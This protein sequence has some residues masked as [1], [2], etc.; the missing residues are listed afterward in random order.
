MMST[1]EMEDI[2]MSLMTAFGSVDAARMWLNMSQTLRGRRGDGYASSDAD[3]VAM[4]ITSG[5][6]RFE[7]SLLELAD[8]IDWSAPNGGGDGV[9]SSG[10]VIVGNTS[11]TPQPSLAS[12]SRRLSDPDMEDIKFYLAGVVNPALCVFGLVGNIFNI[13]VLSRGRMKATLD[14]SMELAAHT[15]L[16]ALAVSDMLYCASAFFDALNSRPQTAFLNSTVWLYIQIYGPYFQNTFLHTGTWLTVIMA[17]GRYAAICR[18]LQARHLVGVKATLGAIATTFLVWIALEL[19]RLWTYAIIPVD[20]PPS[21]D[22]FYVLD[23]GPFVTNVRLKMAFTYVWAVV[24]FFLPVVTLFYC[25]VH[26]IRALRESIRV[27]RLY[28]VS[29]KTTSPGSRIS[30]TLVAIVCMYIVLISPSEVLHFYYYTVDGDDVEVFNMAIVVTNVLQTLNFAFNFVLYC[31]VNVH[32]RQT[33]MEI[34]LCAR[35]LHRWQAASAC[36]GHCGAG[37]GGGG[38][39]TADGGG[40]R[41]GE[42]LR[43][44]WHNSSISCT[45]VYTRGT[46]VGKSVYETAL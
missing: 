13:L 42:R 16:I 21:A 5:D 38:G 40:M 11:A 36:C 23:E 34:L 43:R 10:Y 24:G 19:P 32:F 29:A 3:D 37:G 14:C 1:S 46:Y 2:C 8:G 17:A 45:V 22:R 41:R 26:L 20:C 18:P 12:S 31:I 33:S 27:R 39:G 6:D 4:T 15:G 30:P 25:N 35:R 7:N 9:E 28:R 44:S